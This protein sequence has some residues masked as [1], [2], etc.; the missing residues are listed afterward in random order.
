MSS[1]DSAGDLSILDLSTVSVLRPGCSVQYLF[2]VGYVNVEKFDP[3]LITTLGQA[4]ATWRFP[5]GE[6]C[7][8]ASSPIFVNFSSRKPFTFIVSS[9]PTAVKM[10]Q[11]F[12]L[13]FLIHNISSSPIRPRLVAVKSKMEGIVLSG[14]TGLL[15][16]RLEPGESFT[17]N[18]KAIALEP[19]I[20]TLHGIRITE[21]EKDKIYDLNSVLTV[22][23]E[24]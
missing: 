24:L 12:N 17:F 8:L 22:D 10:Q 20:Q 3:K 5:M 21:L 4:T 14:L 1:A 7:S 23:A 9:V 19:G 2:E 13:A 18:V 16:P 6:P 11:A 15:A